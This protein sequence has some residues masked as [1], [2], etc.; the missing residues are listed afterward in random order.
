MTTGPAGPAG[1]GPDHDDVDVLL[2]AGQRLPAGGVWL[3][4]TGV[5]GAPGGQ[6]T[7]QVLPEAGASAFGGDVVVRLLPDDPAA[8]QPPPAARVLV[9][10]VLCGRMIWVGSWP[11]QDLDAWPERIRPVV[12]FAMSVLTELEEVSVALDAY[13]RVDLR[14][15][16]GQAM[17]GIPL[18]A[19]DLGKTA[20]QGR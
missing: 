16:A 12:A 6:F 7:A 9:Y 5:D 17:A 4:V 11:G 14:Q 10:A 3:L 2:L 20:P 19:F 8:G 18:H 13:V 15:A 1:D